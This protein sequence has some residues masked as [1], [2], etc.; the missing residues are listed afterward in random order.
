LAKYGSQKHFYNIMNLCY[1]TIRYVLYQAGKHELINI[2]ESK[3][4]ETYSDRSKSSMGRSTPK[5]NSMIQ[6]TLLTSNK[7]PAANR[8]SQTTIAPYKSKTPNSKRTSG[9]SSEKGGSTP[10]HAKKLY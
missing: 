5:G 10:K 9:R 6:H 3:V 2:G 1:S 7:S 4:N 8:L